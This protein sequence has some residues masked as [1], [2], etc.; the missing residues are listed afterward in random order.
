MLGSRVTVFRR[1]RPRDENT[2]KVLN[3][4]IYEQCYN[5][6]FVANSLGWCAT[7]R[8]LRDAHKN[9]IR[10]GI[11]KAAPLFSLK[12]EPEIY[13]LFIEACPPLYNMTSD[14]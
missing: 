2:V 3:F 11:K 4:G 8:V 13:E 14:P 12:K 7:L 5:H 6:I 10:S 9:G 1:S